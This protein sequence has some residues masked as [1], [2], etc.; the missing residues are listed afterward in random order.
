MYYLNNNV[1]SYKG[2]QLLDPYILTLRA[3]MEQL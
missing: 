1:T 2:G 3:T